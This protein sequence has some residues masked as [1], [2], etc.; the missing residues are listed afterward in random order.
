[1][2]GERKVRIDA[3]GGHMTFRAGTVGH[4]LFM[5]DVGMAFL[6]GR[7]IAGQIRLERPVR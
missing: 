7:V 5:R 4:A 6:T 2:I 3:H 1:M